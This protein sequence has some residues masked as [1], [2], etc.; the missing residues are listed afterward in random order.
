MGDVVPGVEEALALD[1]KSGVRRI[2]R[3][4]IIRSVKICTIFAH[5]KVARQIISI[6]IRVGATERLDLKVARLL[7]ESRGTYCHL[8]GGWLV[9][10]EHFDHILFW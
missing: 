5:R 2:K 3:R 1:P 9:C 6:F 7:G 10:F 4:L 8:L